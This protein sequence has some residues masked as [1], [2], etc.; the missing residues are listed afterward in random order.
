MDDPNDDTLTNIERLEEE[1][2]EGGVLT[3][4]RIRRAFLRTWQINRKL[5]RRL[6]LLEDALRHVMDKE[7]PTYAKH[8]AVSTIRRE[9]DE[10]KKENRGFRSKLLGIVGAIALVIVK[11]VLDQLH[12]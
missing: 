11:W 9:L 2:P 12:K 6:S 3:P 8:S 5:N 7:L 4:T 10:I 1:F